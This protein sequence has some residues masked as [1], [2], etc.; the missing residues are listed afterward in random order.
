MK[1]QH[2]YILLFLLLGYSL[3]AQT[4]T[5]TT[6]SLTDCLNYAKTQNIQIKKDQI[7][8][9]QTQSDLKAS[10]AQW[11]PSIS[12]SVTQ[13]YTNY[14]EKSVAVHNNYSGNY[15]ISA[16]WSI[17]NGFSRTNS[18]KIKKTEEA[19]Q[20]LAIKSSTNDIS[21]AILQSYLQI[22]Y[23]IEAVEI[24]KMTLETSNTQKERAEKLLKA[25]SLSQSDYALIESEYSSDKYQLVMSKSNLSNY[26]L[27]L[28][29]LLELDINQDIELTPLNFQN[30][31]I[32]QTL[33]SKET[34]YKNS[35]DTMPEIKSA[36]LNIESAKYEIKKAKS[37]YYPNLN[38]TTNIGSHHNTPST[39]EN[40]FWNSYNNNVGLS[41][42]IPIYSQRQNKT[43]VEK[44]KLSAQNA[45]LELNAT[46]KNLLK[47]VEAVYLDTQ[48]AQEQY[49]AANEKLKAI[50]KSFAL[51]NEQFNVGMKNTL[52]LL[53]E[54][55]NLLIAQQE[56]L[57]SKYMVILNLQLLNFYQTQTITL[58]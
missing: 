19:I 55:N 15:G 34:I 42:Q 35:L 1:F 49:V 18:I 28:K 17:F 52:E 22:L 27:Q 45:E 2:Y 23:S 57:Q 24:S 3:T 43:S 54:K 33:P 11:A 32:L 40:Q 4:P 44:A 6:W 21:I 29:Q 14:P 31:D 13:V 50:E 36:K 46:Q 25:G 10:K 56:V 26:K 53:T 39:I 12:A 9:E 8:L 58:P 38:L 7:S 41:L 51:V 16:S 30:I 48:V 47:T 20:K 37:G 5:K